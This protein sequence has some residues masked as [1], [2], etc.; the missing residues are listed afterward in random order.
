[1]KKGKIQLFLCSVLGLVAVFGVVI[2]NP[3][4][5]ESTPLLTFP[6]PKR[7]L[8]DQCARREEQRIDSTFVAERAIVTDSIEY[9]RFVIDSSEIRFWLPNANYF[10]TLWANLA[11]ASADGR[12][13][14]ILHYGDSQIEMDH[15]TSRLRSYMQRTFG[16]G[17][18]GMMPFKTITPSLTV[19]HDSYGDLKHLAS[20]GDSTVIRSRGNYGIMMQCFRLD[21]GEAIVN[22]RASRSNSVDDRVKSFR[23][24]TLIS[25]ARSPLSTSL[26]DRDNKRTYDTRRITNG[27]GRAEWE[28]DTASTSVRLLANGAADLY[29]VLLDSS[30]GV[31][32]DNI[33]MRGCSG[34]QF[35]MVNVDK[36]TASY[37]QMSVGLVIMQFGGNS[38]PYFHT[39]KSISDYC[40]SM[41]KQIDYV[42]S[43]CPGAL[44]L[45]VGPSDMS[46]R[47]GG[48]LQ[49]YPIIPELVD[50]LASTAMR[51][52]AAY[53]SI[54]HAM[55][56]NG[57]MPQ[58][59]SKGLAGKDYIHFTQKGAD[60]MGDKMSE[61]FN[62]SYRL[63]Q[64]EERSRTMEAQHDAAKADFKKAKIV[65]KRRHK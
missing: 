20:F 32:V 38:V 5:D 43:C 8:E 55:G 52:G 13:V 53:W 50:S 56:G 35:T 48:D 33:P 22:Y 2:P 10:D 64:L 19:R 58:W 46:R 29:C 28:L 59:T 14:R 1:M 15:I 42:K 11:T 65:K 30:A 44:I 57:S 26:T 34:Q 25:D 63:Y 37:D 49:S 4:N 39:T 41:G 31:A 47:R 6:T 54:Y 36:L 60:L 7:F 3:G 27:V 9:Y 40:Q 18:P 12:I 51:H 24:V 62:A 21:G 23:R 61:A 17:G 45:F 16:G